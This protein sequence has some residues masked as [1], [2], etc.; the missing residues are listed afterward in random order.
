MSWRC[1]LQDS[2]SYKQLTVTAGLRY[3]NLNGYLPEQDSPPSRFFPNLVRTFAEVPDVVNWNTVGPR[4]SAAY[5]L[6][7]NG[8]T[9]LKAAA[10]RYYYVIA[11]GGGIL[12]GVNPNANYQE[13]YRWNDAQRRSALPAG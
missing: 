12:D 8:R 11:S 6:M 5:D 10:G 13:Q 7:G 1:T 4:I 9:G 3:E 2:M